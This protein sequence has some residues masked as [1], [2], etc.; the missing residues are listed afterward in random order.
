MPVLWSCPDPNCPPTAIVPVDVPEYDEAADAESEP[1]FTT[2]EVAML[3][4]VPPAT[5]HQ[6]H[7]EGTGLRVI[8]RTRRAI[9]EG[10]T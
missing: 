5:V 4:N 3:L 8:R 9:T 7:Q 6:W 10:S 2:D 1:P